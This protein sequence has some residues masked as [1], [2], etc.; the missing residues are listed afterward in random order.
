MRLLLFDEAFLGHHAIWMEEILRAL[1]EVAPEHELLYAFPHAVEA[2]GTHIEWR[3]PKWH[4][5]LRKVQRWT[6]RPWLAAAKWRAIRKL[7]EQAR[8]DRVL[9]LYADE[10]LHPAYRPSVAF[11]WVPIYFHPRFLRGDS[12][13]PPLA[14]LASSGC[15]FVYVLDSGVVE[16]LSAVLHKPVVRI[17]DFCPAASRRETARC[18]AV[19]TAAAGR[20]VIGAIGPVT[21]HKNV[22]TLL[23]IAQQRQDWHFLIAG[24]VFPKALSAEERTLLAEASRM[25]NISLVPE[26]LP[27]DELN[28]LTAMCDVQYA[29]YTNFLHSSN[30]LVR[31]CEYRKPL[32]VADNG[33]MAEMV[34]LYGLGETCDPESDAS[35][36]E[37]LAACLNPRFPSPDWQG[38]MARNSLDRLR[39]AMG[40]FVAPKA[41]EAAAVMTALEL[42][43]P[44]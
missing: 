37:A 23:R 25:T 15:P 6:G 11:E 31:A 14:T 13:A 30:K 10:F 44:K 1:A 21:R 42:K 20:P 3:E 41:G 28:A 40:P 7:A 8:A 4:H 12:A 16:A 34:R 32:V 24:V 38:Y 2:V 33:C 27:H 35:V 39:V 19:R 26:Y 17:P 9:L 36:V 18:D 5:V 43:E 29:A 22:G